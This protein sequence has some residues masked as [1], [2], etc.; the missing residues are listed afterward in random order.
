MNHAIG[1]LQPVPAEDNA[2]IQSSMRKLYKKVD[3][4]SKTR[5]YASRRLKRHARYSGYVI[6]GVSLL[7]I[8][9]ALMQSYGL[10]EMIKSPY[11]VLIQVFSSVLVLCYSLSIE[12]NNYS[13][14]A[15]KLY[16]CAAALG[17]LKVE[18]TPFLEATATHQQ[19]KQFHGDYHNILARYEAEAVDEF[20]VDYLRARLDMKEDYEYHWLQRALEKVRIFVGISLNFLHYFIIL[21]VALSALGWITTGGVLESSTKVA[22]VLQAGNE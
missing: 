22:N 19:Y 16:S 9:I 1:K 4:T 11:I 17:K 18:M 3:A 14:R 10:G 15:D 5:F 7:L 20:H 21:L 13:G 2:D 12:K 8:F 6:A